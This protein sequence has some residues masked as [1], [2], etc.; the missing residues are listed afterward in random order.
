MTP[1][2]ATRLAISGL[3]YL[4]GDPE[5]LSRFVALTGIAPNAIRNQAN[6]PAFLAAVLDYFLGD[7]PTLLA[8][9]ASFDIK[10]EDILKARHA[11]VPPD[12]VDGWE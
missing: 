10:P 8:F 2:A 1:E 7:E 12:I 11:L 4:G 5:Q 9:A 6:S 3:Q